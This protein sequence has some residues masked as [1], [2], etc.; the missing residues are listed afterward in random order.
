MRQVR[1]QIEKVWTDP[2]VQVTESNCEYKTAKLDVEIGLFESGSCS[3][4]RSFAR[5]ESNST[6]RTP[7][8]QS[9]SP[10]PIRPYPLRCS[11]VG[12][13]SP[14]RSPRLGSAQ[15]R[16]SPPPG[17]TPG[18]ITYTGPQGRVTPAARGS[19]DLKAKR[20]TAPAPAPPPPVVT[21]RRNTRRRSAAADADHVA[22]RRGL[23]G[24][25]RELAAGPVASDEVGEVGEQH[26]GRIGAV[27][28]SRLQSSRV[29]TRT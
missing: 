5:R 20:S 19:I 17:S 15:A 18:S 4:S 1:K 9:V 12:S 26:G 27:P 10:R 3:T 8:T 21:Q 23:S 13:A 14:R 28:C 2:C 22:V 7:S 16:R 29:R 25:A 11:P 24:V 6:T